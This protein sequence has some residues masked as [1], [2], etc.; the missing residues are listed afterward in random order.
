MYRRT[1][2]RPLS[3]RPSLKKAKW[4]QRVNVF[5][6][7]R[8]RRA[9][10]LWKSS[11]EHTPPPHHT[12]IYTESSPKRKLHDPIREKTSA[13]ERNFNQLSFFFKP[14]AH[15][16]ITSTI[17]VIPPPPPPPR[18][19]EEKNWNLA[20][21]LIRRLCFFSSVTS[22][23]L[24]DAPVLVRGG[25]TMSPVPVP[26]PFIVTQTPPPHTHTHTKSIAAGS[27]G[28]QQQLRRVSNSW[29]QKPFKNAS[30]ALSKHLFSIYP[31]HE[32][33][34]RPAGKES[35]WGRRRSHRASPRKTAGV[36][37]NHTYF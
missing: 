25:H 12:H 4:K 36:S 15:I 1:G 18:P 34:G 16:L 6:W 33:T 3:A 30:C 2:P 11:V 35:T 29:I 21:F 10:S 32:E 14:C 20:P 17:S 13:P 23:L 28:R 8:E 27:A 26:D 22:C 24:Q 31:P 37:A 5:W 19:Q 9:P 7:G